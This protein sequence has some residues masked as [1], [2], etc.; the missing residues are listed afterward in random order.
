M[1]AAETPFGGGVS[2]RFTRRLKGQSTIEYVLIIAVIGLVIVFAGPGVAGAIRNQFN[3]ITNTVD[4]GT[5]G[6]SF[7][8]AE[9]KAYRE[10]M[11]TVVN[12]DAKDWTLDEQK[13]AATDIAKNGTSSVV[14][15]KARAAMD[16]GTKWS[17][18]LT[19]GKTMTYR[20]IGINHDDLA[21]GSGKAGLTFLTTSTTI[22]SRMNAENFNTGGWEKSELR[23]K[24][25]SGEIWNLMPSDFQSKVK[26]VKKLTNNVDGGEENK[27][28]T[29]TATSDRLFLLSYSEIVP[30]SCWASDY[31]APDALDPEP[32]PDYPWTPSDYP[33]TSSEGAQYEAFRGKVTNNFSGNSAIAIGNRWWERS[34]SVSPNDYDS[35][36]SVGADGDPTGKFDLA[37]NLYCVCPAFSF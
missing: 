4:S 1:H 23:Q 36:L 20:I 16:A 12:K 29:A 26:S 33:W 7:M 15:A 17:I 10:S 37:T 30:T 24:L 21:D 3:Q 28:A 8:S 27:N 2:P 22:S 32:A 9:E 14:Y 34:V 35:F 19:N 25:N 13:A 18:K 5:D 6:D 31:P 11:K